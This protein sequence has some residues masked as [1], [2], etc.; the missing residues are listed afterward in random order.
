[1]SA[2]WFAEEL[3]DEHTG[4]SLGR[5]RQKFHVYQYKIGGPG[6]LRRTTLCHGV[7][8]VVMVNTSIDLENESECM[9]WL[10]GETG[11]LGM[12]RFPA[13]EDLETKL[14]ATQYASMCTRCKDRYE[15]KNS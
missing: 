1:M 15:R 14:T 6:A 7:Q 9:A 8:G 2:E 12:G 11:I 4:Y 3:R 13:G 10:N 5:P